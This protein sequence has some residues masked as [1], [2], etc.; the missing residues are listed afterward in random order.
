MEDKVFVN[1]EQLSQKRSELMGAFEYYE[2]KHMSSGDSDDATLQYKYLLSFWRQY[3]SRSLNVSCCTSSSENEEIPSGEKIQELLNTFET[4]LVRSYS[5]IELSCQKIEEM[6]RQL[7]RC[8]NVVS[9]DLIL[10]A[11]VAY[12]LSRLLYN[13][14]L[15]TDCFFPIHEMPYD[16]FLDNIKNRL[17]KCIIVS[18]L[19]YFGEYFEDIV[20]DFNED[21]VSVKE[22]T[23][24]I[25]NIVGVLSFKCHK[26]K[27]A[28][29]YFRNAINGYEKNK[30]DRLYK[31][32]EYFQTKLLLAYCY[33]YNHDFSSAIKELIGIDEVQL[34][35][36]FE[37]QFEEQKLCLYD[38]LDE[39]SFFENRKTSQIIIKK[40]EEKAER[41]SYI[42]LLHLGMLRDGEIDPNEKIGDAHEVL[43]SLGHC[44]NE[45]GIKN[46][47][48][49]KQKRDTVVKLLFLARVI[50]LEVAEQNEYCEDFQTC[51]YMVYGESKD[52]DLCLERINK[53]TGK[54]KHNPYKNINYYMENQFYR[55]LVYYQS[56]RI[57]MSEEEAD[58]AYSEFKK[59]A[60]LRDD[61]DALIHIEI[62]RFRSSIIKI[63]REESDDTILGVLRELKNEP[64]G[65]SMFDYR[66]SSKANKWIVQ[67]YNKTIALYE[68]LVKY[69]ESTGKDINM[70]YNLA[71]RFIYFR[72]MFEENKLIFPEGITKED[73]IEQTIDL[74]MDDVASPQSI[75]LL[76]PL[77]SAEP[78][79]HQTK[80]LLSLE[81]RLFNDTECSQTFDEEFNDKL[82]KFQRLQEFTE[83]S[84][85]VTKLSKWLFSHN[86]YSPLFLVSKSTSNVKCDRYYY[87]DYR[88]VVIER[89][90]HNVDSINKLLE[91]IK[92]KRTNK[93]HIPCGNH[94]TKCC[95]TIPDIDSSK[96]NTFMEN[97]V[98]SITKKICEELLLPTNI[99][100]EAHFVIYYKGTA[101]KNSEWCIIGLKK[102]LSKVLGSEMIE[103]LCEEGSENMGNLCEKEKGNVPQ[104]K[105]AISYHNFCYVEYSSI[106]AGIATT[107]MLFLQNHGFHL[108]FDKE[109]INEEKLT[110]AKH[111]LLFISDKTMIDKGKDRYIEFVHKIFDDTE[112]RDRLSVIAYGFSKQNDMKKKLKEQGMEDS[113]INYLVM[114]TKLRNSS[115][116]D[117]TNHM[118]DIM[119]QLKND[120]V[121][122]NDF[123]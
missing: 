122:Q 95:I 119:V 1:Y 69:F 105:L 96:Q 20:D 106:D 72:N 30:T 13:I 44:L 90:I 47:A 32:D 17:N 120:G 59:F 54:I 34:L 9:D 88:D 108:F 79:Q 80:S 26:Y 113:V 78:Y 48:G 85:K 35:S 51:L 89:P 109:R 93:R 84:K 43:H 36:L 103:Y 86:E 52:Y 75:F 64:E 100:E 61:Y 102:P 117:Y 77:T 45:L 39:D 81:R 10:E 111:I 123:S 68:F 67:E 62:I 112:L 2:K 50:M 23:P 63:L 74:I 11:K 65:K 70:L 116:F 60:L 73:A 107:D 25:Q 98:I 66:P 28:I 115:A 38:L 91:A 14:L 24:H 33:E 53:I 104:C 118:H 42:N 97:G 16:D 114:Q 40:I 82:G 83:L 8:M 71:C 19:D 31:S 6:R 49:T 3:L 7:I 5:P 29:S 87:A 37:K 58:E 46:K 41:G 4:T 27:E 55:F 76:A 56:N 101:D 92:G 18:Q 22:V 99:Y 57:I 15:L 12:R 94:Q 110:K 121:G 21:F